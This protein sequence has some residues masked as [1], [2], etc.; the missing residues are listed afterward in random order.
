MQDIQ[1]WCFNEPQLD[2]QLRDWATD[3]RHLDE[4][5]DAAKQRFETVSGFLYSRQARDNGLL[6]GFDLTKPESTP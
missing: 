1:Y 3:P 2:Q 4:S 5:Q 6:K